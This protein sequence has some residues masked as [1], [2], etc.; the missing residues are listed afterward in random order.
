MATRQFFRKA[1]LLDKQPKQPRPNHYAKRVQVTFQGD[2]QS[3]L[4]S[5]REAALRVGRSKGGYSLHAKGKAHKWTSE[6]ARKA[7]KKL[8]RTRWRAMRAG[9]KTIGS[10]IRIGRPAMKRAAVDHQAMRVKYA[11]NIAAPG[12]P[13]AWYDPFGHTWW[14]RGQQISERTA[15]RRLGHLPYPRKDPVPLTVRPVDWHHPCSKKAN[16]REVLS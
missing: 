9:G 12:Q 3:K 13:S 11:F 15:L 10:P 2:P 16:T 6:T 1:H 5:S 4:M 14:D 7:A 8:W